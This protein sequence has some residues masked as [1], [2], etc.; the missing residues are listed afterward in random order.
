VCPAQLPDHLLLQQQLLG[1][2]TCW[3][4]HPMLEGHQQ[5]QQG[6]QSVHHQ[7]RLPL[8]LLLLCCSLQRPHHML[9][10]WLAAEGTLAQRAA[11]LTLI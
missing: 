10:H 9:L 11:Y 6:W 7:P 8:L 1:Y 3:L 2:L 5:K 4:T